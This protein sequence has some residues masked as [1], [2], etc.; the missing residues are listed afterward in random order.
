MRGCRSAPVPHTRTAEDGVKFL[1]SCVQVDNVC[2]L[3][4]VVRGLRRVSKCSAEI[5]HETQRLLQA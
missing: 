5:G 2:P 4:L 1:A 3:P